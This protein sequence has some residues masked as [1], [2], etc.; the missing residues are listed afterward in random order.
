VAVD[1]SI[2]EVA[3]DYW[4]ANRAKAQD[5]TYWMAHPLCRQAINRRINGNPHE[6]PLDWF[7]RVH[8][9]TPFDRGISWGCGLGAFERAAIRTGIVR[10]IDA[11]DIS[12]ASLT[13]AR[14]EAASESILGIDYKIGNFDDPRIL[15][16]H[17]D[18]VFFQ[19]SLHHVAA[20]ERLFRRLSFGLKPGGFV[21]LDEFIGPSRFH[22]SPP[23]LLLAQSVL[24]LAPPEARLRDRITEPIE[25]ND[26]SEGYRPDEIANFMKDFFD[27][28]EWRPYGGQVAGLVFPNLVPEWTYTEPGLRFVATMLQIED[29]ELARDPSTTHHL[30]A[31]GRLKPLAR[32]AA[33]LGRQVREALVRRLTTRRGAAPTSRPG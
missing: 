15:R 11:F 3:A 17:Y 6:W 32:L 10:T 29:Y 14:R 24:D 31:C 22:W 26:L 23:L 18:I 16:R 5:P 2:A 9:S 13:D 7:K 20:M 8:A 1:P 21:Y 19:S 27:I 12:E 33:P 30:V 28:L 4:D 25:V